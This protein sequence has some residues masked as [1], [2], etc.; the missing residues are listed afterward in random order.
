M[1]NIN[2]IVPGNKS[3]IRRL[4]DYSSDITLL[5]KKIICRCFRDK[6]NKTMQSYND[7]SETS[8]TRVSNIVSSTLGGK[9]TFG[10]FNRPAKI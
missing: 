8:A 6:V 7:S 9:T 5:E 3:H 10:N 1:S 2:F 4:I